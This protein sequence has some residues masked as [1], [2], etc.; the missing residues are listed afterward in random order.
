MCGLL[1][2]RVVE[3]DLDAVGAGFLEA[4]NAPDVEQVGQAAGGLR[5]VAGLLVGEQQAG[6][7]AQLGGGQA[8]LGIEQNRRGVAGEHVGHQLL[9]DLEIV[10]VG[11]G[12][13]L[14]GERLLQRT[15][16]VHG[17]GGDDA[18]RV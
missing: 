6:V 8:E 18:A 12:A 15:T 16:L 9:E 2:R 3:Q 13:A 14:L 1:E 17:G 5:V 10:A 7:V 4:A 11:G